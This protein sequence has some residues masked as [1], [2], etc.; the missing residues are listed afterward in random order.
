[1]IFLSL[2]AYSN[3]ILPFLAEHLKCD[4]P[5]VLQRAVWALG[6]LGDISVFDQ[7]LEAYNKETNSIF[8]ANALEALAKIDPDQAAT[9]VL[10]AFMDEDSF[11]QKRA[12]WIRNSIY[13]GS[14]AQQISEDPVELVET[15]GCDEE[16]P[17]E[18]HELDIEDDEEEDEHEDDEE[19]DESFFTYT[20]K[21]GIDFKLKIDLVPS[22]LWGDSL[23]QQCKGAGNLSKWRKFKKEL[24]EN[25]GKKCWFCGEAEGRLIAH[26]FYEYNDKVHLQTLKEIHHICKMCEKVRMIGKWLNAPN[27][28]SEFGNMGIRRDITDQFC[29]VNNCFPED[30]NEY[31]KGVME[32]WGIRSEHS[33]FQEFGEYEYLIED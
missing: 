17:I 26:S 9:V 2:K 19:D 23:F 28:Y 13:H 5:S 33:W 18:G 3:E 4:Q 10:H 32:I 25:E 8:R 27:N 7:I 31:E 22:S 21:L 16:F 24:V 29:K 6:E 30:F 20:P 14:L 1:M 11:I 15:A 12:Q